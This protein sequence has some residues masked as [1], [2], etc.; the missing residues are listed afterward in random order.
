MKIGE[1][2]KKKKRMRT[3]SSEFVT[4]KEKEYRRTGERKEAG[5]ASEASQ[6]G[7]GKL[8]A[9][10]TAQITN[11]NNNNNNVRGQCVPAKPAEDKNGA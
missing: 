9:D 6:P 1:I 10:E 11:K 5:S 3:S 7:R 4:S 2:E 8:Q